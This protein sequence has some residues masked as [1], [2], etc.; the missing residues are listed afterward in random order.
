MLQD[1]MLKGPLI[2]LMRQSSRD[3]YVYTGE[4]LGRPHREEEL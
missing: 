4:T 3:L 1:F 2:R